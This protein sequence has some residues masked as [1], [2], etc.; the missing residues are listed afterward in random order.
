[1]LATTLN[2]PNE[3]LGSY[4]VGV[5][6]AFYYVDNILAYRKEVY[7]EER[8]RKYP[9]VSFFNRYPS[10]GWVFVLIGVFLI[11]FDLFVSFPAI[12]APYSWSNTQ[13]MLYMALSRTCYALGC[14]FVLF[15]ILLGIFE[16][17]KKGLTNCYFRIGGKIAFESAL[18]HPIVIG[19]FFDRTVDGLYITTPN[20][21]Y[22]GAGN[23]FCNYLVGMT[24]Y[25]LVEYPAA[26]II[27]WT[28]GRFISH[29]PLVRKH[30]MNVLN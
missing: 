23:I 3:K 7:P 20:N 5:V 15:A 16:V 13:N 1:M 9:I 24:V 4:A 30:Q 11:F 17:G 25:V 19:L 27:R 29:D 10:F 22:F 21:L 12:A 14:A 6:L 28:V 8:R 18:L 26:M 2:K